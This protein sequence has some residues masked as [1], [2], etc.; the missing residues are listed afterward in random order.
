MSLTLRHL[1]IQLRGRSTKSTA[2]TC[3]SYGD[4]AEEPAPPSKAEIHDDEPEPIPADSTQDQPQEAFKAE[5]SDNVNNQIM[6][7]AVVQS[8]QGM[9]GGQQDHEDDYD[10]PIS[11][12]DDG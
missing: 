8:M 1:P 5:A 2:L 3:D 10:K 4:E 6:P 11:I 7:E 9:Q 12:K